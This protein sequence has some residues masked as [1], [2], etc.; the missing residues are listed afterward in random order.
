MLGVTGGRGLRNVGVVAPIQGIE[1][2]S[3]VNYSNQSVFSSQSVSKYHLI[4]PVLIDVSYKG[5]ITIQ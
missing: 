5:H 3:A 2:S 1:V 4:D